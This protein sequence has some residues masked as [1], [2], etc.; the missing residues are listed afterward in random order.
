MAKVRTAAQRV[1]KDV[2][3]LK[4]SGQGGLRKV[5]CPR[6]RKQVAPAPDSRKNPIYRCTCGHSFQS[7]AM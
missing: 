5:R 4:T 2:V 3:V 7:T 6:C 1:T